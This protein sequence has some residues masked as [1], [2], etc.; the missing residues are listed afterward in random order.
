MSVRGWL[1]SLAESG[2]LFREAASRGNVGVLRS[3]LGPAWRGLV[4]HQAKGTSATRMPVEHAVAFDWS[5]QRDHVEMTKLYE[6]AKTS[7]WNATSDLDW[8]I[9]V[10]PHDPARPLLPES[11]VPPSHLPIFQR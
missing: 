5:Y 10:D 11:Y 3:L 9:S 1:H 8:S 4:L 2:P 7:Q 6:A